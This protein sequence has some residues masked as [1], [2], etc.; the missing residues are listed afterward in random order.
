MDEKKAS[1]PEPIAIIGTS[2][3]LPGGVNSPSKLWELLKAPVDLLTDVPSTRFEPA[4]FYHRNPEHPGTTNVTKAYLLEEDP[5]TF[6]NDFFNISAREAESMDPQQR[7]LLEIAYE[8]IESSGYSIS[9]LRGSSTGVF[10]GQMS[11]DYR[12][13]ILRDVDSHPLY[14]G[15]G[16]A[17]SILANRVSYAFD[18]RGPSVN[19]DTACSSSLVALHQAVQSIRNE[20]CDIAVV[21]GVNLVFSPELFSFLSS[22]HMLSPTG[23]SRM[24]DVS[25]DGYARGEG[26]AAIV[27]KP[28]KKAIADGDDIE[29][30]IR[31]TGVNQDGRSAGLTVPSAA[32]QAELMRKTYAKCGLDYLKDEDRCQYFEAHG[33]GKLFTLTKIL[34]N[35]IISLTQFRYK[36]WRPERGGGYQHDLFSKS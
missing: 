25:A 8:A 6:D 12:D 23:R 22:L 18:W 21:A 33:T 24:W 31:N 35:E 28:L 30:V 14:T 16:I 17:R 13:L 9:Q 36:G 1:I 19:V 27:I 26:F 34:F 5:L 20:E 29:S 32:A 2:C 4:A 3:R 10:V 15:T 11:D 7:I